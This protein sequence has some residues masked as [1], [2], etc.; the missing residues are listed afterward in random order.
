MCSMILREV[1]PAILL[2]T[3]SLAYIHRAMASR[4][5]ITEALQQAVSNSGQSLYAICQATGLNEDSLSRFMRGQTSMRLDLADKLAN[6]FGIECR[7][8]RRKGE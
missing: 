4:N 3:T 8:T 1:L 7:R 2:T 6:Y 5:V